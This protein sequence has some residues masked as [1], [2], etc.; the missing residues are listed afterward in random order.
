MSKIKKGVSELD[1]VLDALTKEGKEF[2]KKFN[3][4]VQNILQKEIRS[5]YGH[6]LDKVGLPSL[7]VTLSVSFSKAPI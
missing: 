5:A 1:A 3:S 2:Y 6:D 4:T 7:G